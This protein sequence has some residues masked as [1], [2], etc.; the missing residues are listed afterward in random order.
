MPITTINFEDLQSE[1]SEAMG[2][3]FETFKRKNKVRF[4]RHE[5]EIVVSN[6]TNFNSD[7]PNPYL[8]NI[9]RQADY[10]EFDCRIIFTRK[11]SLDKIISGDENININGANNRGEVRLQFK[12]E[13]FEFLEHSQVFWIEGY[14][15]VIAS[16]FRMLGAMQEFE[17]FEI[18]LNR[19][20]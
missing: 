11:P 15:Y 19:N 6:D 12:R 13:A 14:R 8:E 17:Y 20:S 4:Y 16:D 3:V 7:F 10:A 2:I 9:T 1:F 18:V 5:K